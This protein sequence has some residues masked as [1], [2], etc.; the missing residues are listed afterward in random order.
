MKHSNHSKI[1]SFA[2]PG[3]A[4]ISALALTFGLSSC[5]EEPTPATDDPA[6]PQVKGSSSSQAQG[7]AAAP[8]STL[9]TKDKE[10]L[11]KKLTPIQYEVAVESG[12]ERAFQ[13]EYW[14]NKEPGIYVDIISGKPLFASTHKFK[15]GTGWPSFYQPLVKEEVVEVTDTKHGMVRSEVRSKSGD[16][17]LGHVFPDGPEPTG[18]RYCVN[19]AS[20]RF[21]PKD[22]LAE[23][24]LEEYLKLFGEG[25]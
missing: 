23:E 15:S 20:L 14:D 16:T 25:S 3:F 1:R 10:A 21:V 7:G 2:Y 13:N 5:E 17:H 9:T 11:K 22:K 12:T 8:A 4:T 18:L 19:S 24:G 6:A